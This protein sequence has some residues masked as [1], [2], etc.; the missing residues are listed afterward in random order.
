M[1]SNSLFVQSHC[2]LR[3]SVHVG[4]H[5]LHSLRIMEVHY[6]LR[7]TVHVQRMHVHDMHVHNDVGVYVGKRVPITSNPT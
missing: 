2:A 4:R 3:Y 7:C 5:L 6:A 1:Q